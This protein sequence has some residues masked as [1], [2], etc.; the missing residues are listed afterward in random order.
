MR[1]T[2]PGGHSAATQNAPAPGKVSFRS[3]VLCHPLHL[4]E[5]FESAL[6]PSEQ[7]NS[8]RA[9]ARPAVI[10]V[11][12]AWLR[13]CVFTGLVLL[14]LV[15]I[16]LVS[17][18]VPDRPRE[19]FD[20]RRL[21][22]LTELQPELVLLGNSMVGTRFEERLLQRLLR[23]RRVAVLGL[24]G[25]RSATW[26]LA[27][28]N[29][30]VASGARPRVIQF[31]RDTELTEPRVHALGSDHARL[32]VVSTQDDPQVER[33]LTPPWTEPVTWL[34][35]RLGH[36][37]PIGRLHQESASVAE[38]FG[39]FSSSMFWRG[40]GEPARKREINNLFAM[41]NLRDAPEPSDAESETVSPRFGEV[42][43]GSLLPD[44]CTLAEENRIPLTFVRVRTRAAAEGDTES[45]SSRQYIRD[46]EQYV[47]KRGAEFYDM[48][49]ATWERAGLFGN[50]DHID[51]RY[52]RRY[53]TLFVEHMGEILH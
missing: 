49:D 25:S 14:A 27:L 28:K 36:A 48:H 52:R 53:T 19:P 46:L 42:L 50:G 2:V 16:A 20:Q 45:A 7:P 1:V 32:E 38:A 51:S 4:Y 15:S 23:P 31:F 34:G 33:K 39:S 9:D 29:L 3:A 11:G 13:L 30:I 10:G 47:R 21:T 40:V 41:A 8:A 12:Q 44:I 35:F 18:A 6:A 24:A 17:R 5:L 22:E 37:F 26:F 43:A